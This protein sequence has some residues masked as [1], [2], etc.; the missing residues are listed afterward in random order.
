MTTEPQ[1]ANNAMSDNNVTDLSQG[2]ELPLDSLRTCEVV[3]EK[4]AHLGILFPNTIII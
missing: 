4:F 3:A 1:P 2:I